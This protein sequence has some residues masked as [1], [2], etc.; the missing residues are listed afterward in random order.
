MSRELRRKILLASTLPN[1][2]LNRASLIITS[3]GRSVAPSVK[4]IH[5]LKKS[6]R[7]SRDRFMLQMGERQMFQRQNNKSNIGARYAIKRRR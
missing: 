5:D 7:R 6:L 2:Y 1:G 3:L 4:A